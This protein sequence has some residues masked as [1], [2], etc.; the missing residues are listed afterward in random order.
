MW[1]IGTRR[2]PGLRVQLSSI[3][4]AS[5]AERTTTLLRMTGTWRPRNLHYTNVSRIAH[6]EGELQALTEICYCCLRISFHLSPCLAHP[7]R[8]SL[9]LKFPFQSNLLVPEMLQRP[10]HLE[11]L[12]FHVPYVLG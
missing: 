1:P 11:L 2:V 6:M 4:R 5:N 7:L 12:A 10:S 3:M 8:C 9:R